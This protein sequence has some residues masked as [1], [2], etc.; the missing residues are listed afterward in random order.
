MAVLSIL[1]ANKLGDVSNF[2]IGSDPYC[3]VYLTSKKINLEKKEIYRTKTIKKTI[4]PIFINENIEF[5]VPTEV[6]WFHYSILIEI[7][8]S[9]NFDFLGSL[10]LSGQK[11][12]KLLNRTGSNCL[13][14]VE[15]ELQKSPYLPED[16]VR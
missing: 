10:L 6:Y 15:Y 12:K 4:N 16:E 8:D 2:H 3:I 7:W 13:L 5:L 11:L 9:N 1:S 14:P